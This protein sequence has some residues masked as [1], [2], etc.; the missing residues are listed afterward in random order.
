VVDVTG[1]T[2]IDVWFR[3]FEFRFRHD[4]RCL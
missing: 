4:L 1:G 2:D 3:P